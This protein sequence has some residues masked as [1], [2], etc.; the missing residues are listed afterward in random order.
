MRTDLLDYYERELAFLRRMGDEFARKYPR[1]ADRL[2]LEADR[3]ED[4]HVERLIESFAF[5]AARLHLRLDD[6][7]PE[8]TSALLN[9]IYPHYLRPIPTMTVVECQIRDELAKRAR[10]Q[11][12]SLL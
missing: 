9:L 5:M 8:I 11:A 7:L 1:V 6:D 12:G 2:M 4:P 10:I 3:C